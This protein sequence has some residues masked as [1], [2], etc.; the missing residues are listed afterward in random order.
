MYRFYNANT[1]DKFVNDCTIRAISTATNRSWGDTYAE[2]SDEAQKRGMMMDNVD[3]IE[4]Y[5]DDR[6]ERT[7]HYAKTVGEFIE[8]YPVGVFIISMPGHL[9]CVIDGVN[10]DTFDTTERKMW[11]CWKVLD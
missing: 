10:Y 11:C 4:D 8:E 1:H 7:C 5:L 3:F 6:Y 2:L 9:T